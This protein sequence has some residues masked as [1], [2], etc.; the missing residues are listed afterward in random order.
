MST[1]IRIYAT[2]RQLISGRDNK[3]KITLGNNSGDIKEGEINSCLGNK[4]L[5]NDWGGVK[6]CICIVPD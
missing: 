5:R 1:Q 6:N 4:S 2:Q 3:N